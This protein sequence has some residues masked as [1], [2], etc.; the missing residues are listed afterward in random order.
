MSGLNHRCYG[1]VNR[2]G[3]F[4]T[5]NTENEDGG[6]QAAFAAAAEPGGAETSGLSAGIREKFLQK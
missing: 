6:F 1:T 3:G 2:D 5:E 4:I